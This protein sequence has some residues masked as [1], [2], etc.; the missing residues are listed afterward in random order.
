MP[1]PPS[2]PEF[3]AQDTGGSRGDDLLPRYF[4]SKVR[5][6]A[7]RSWPSGLRARCQA[8]GLVDTPCNMS[9]ASRASPKARVSL[10]M[11]SAPLLQ[12]LR[13]PSMADS[14]KPPRQKPCWRCF[15]QTSPSEERSSLQ[16]GMSCGMALILIEESNSSSESSLHLSANP[17]MVS[18]FALVSI[19]DNAMLCTNGA[20]FWLTFVS[21]AASPAIVP[22]S[23]RPT[24]S[25]MARSSNAT[26]GCGTLWAA[27]C[28]EA[29]A[30]IRASNS[31]S[32]FHS[33]RSRSSN[34][35]ASS[36]A[37]RTTRCKA[38]V[39]TLPQASKRSYEF[40]C[41]PNSAS[42]RSCKSAR[43]TKAGTST[44]RPFKVKMAEGVAM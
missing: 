32:F 9:S 20:K 18:N 37:M 12:T 19:C 8:F 36:P 43:H 26:S 7:P 13:R 22:C 33:G 28:C 17:S 42:A 35:Q 30:S 11:P 21:R 24:P 3:M 34:W 14:F 31:R 2:Y 23:A 16:A 10:P 6:P 1:Q 15:C 41:N 38:V 39:S 4:L 40:G 5:C 25:R 29:T 44:L 27:I